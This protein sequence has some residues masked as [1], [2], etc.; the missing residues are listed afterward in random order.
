MHTN[1]TEK[2]ERLL[3]LLGVSGLTPTPV[4]KVFIFRGYGDGGGK[5]EVLVQVCGVATI[6]NDERGPL[7]FVRPVDEAEHE[8]L[9]TIYA[10][11]EGGAI[12]VDVHGH[13]HFI[14]GKLEPLPRH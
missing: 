12:C 2:L 5:V 13:Q 9:R 4:D 11:G 3:D 14:A 8:I 1:K 10:V 6:S 7:V